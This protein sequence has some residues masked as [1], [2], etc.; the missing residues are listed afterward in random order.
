M[1]LPMSVQSVI[2]SGSEPQRRWA[3]QIRK[4]KA[5]ELQKMGVRVIMLALKPHVK[6]GD[7]ESIKC[8]T[9]RD[10]LRLVHS[11]C[12]YSLSSPESKYWIEHREEPVATW[13]PGAY[14]ACLSHY[15]KTQPF[16]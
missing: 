3:D 13:L 15:Q 2:L 8:L 1:N 16:K 9:R 5:A 14:Q 7:L 10:I 6:E 4:K 11:V 12:I